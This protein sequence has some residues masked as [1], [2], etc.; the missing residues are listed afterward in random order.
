MFPHGLKYPQCTVYK[1]VY[2]ILDIIVMHMICIC[3]V[4]ENCIIPHF[5]TSSH[6]K[7]E[8]ADCLLLETFLFLSSESK[9]KKTWF[10]YVT[11]KT[12]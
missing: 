5:Y 7:E 3:I 6:I 11:S 2:I 10:L 8:C 12:K 1:N 9:Y 4:L